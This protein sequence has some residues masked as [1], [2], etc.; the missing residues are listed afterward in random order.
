VRGLEIISREIKHLL[1]KN[2]SGCK[3]FSNQS[4]EQNEDVDVG[5]FGDVLGDDLFEDAGERMPV[6]EQLDIGDCVH[7]AEDED[8]S[9]S[10]AVVVMTRPVLQQYVPTIFVY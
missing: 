9:S 6:F 10:H 5:E 1:P 4:P 2:V 8:S 7:P 3:H